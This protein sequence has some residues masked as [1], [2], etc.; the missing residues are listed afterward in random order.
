MQAL[1]QADVTISGKLTDKDGSPIPGANVFIQGT[2]NGTVTDAEGNYTITVAKGATLRFA[3]AGYNEKKV[4]VGNQ[5]VINLSLDE[6][7]IEAIT[8]TSYGQVIDKTTTTGAMTSVAG[9][10]FETLPLQSFDRAIQGRLAGVAVN[11]ANG[12]P[13]GGLQVR[14][15]G[16][17]SVLASNAPLYIVD[18]VQ[19][20]AGAFSTQA[21]ATGSVTGTNA[22][23][24]INPNDIETVEVLKDAAAAAI[25]GAQS[26]N[27]VVII[28]TKKGKRNSDQ[29]NFTIQE[30]F[31]EPIRLF[32]VL[33][34][35]QYATLKREAA[36]NDLFQPNVTPTSAQ[37]AAAIANANTLYGNPDTT[38]TNFDWVGAV[39]R[40]A[41]LRTYDVNYSGGNDRTRFYISAS[42]Q[43][44]EGQIIRSNW[45]RGSVRFNIDH[46]ASKR[47][48]L[49]SSNTVSN[50][51]IFGL[52]N[53]GEGNF[54]NS[55]TFIFQ[56]A[57]TK[58]AYLPDGSFATYSD[59]VLAFNYNNL[60]GLNL[61]T[62]K[63]SAV[64][65]VSSLKGVYNIL[66]SL[67]FTSFVGVDWL[68]NRDENIRP[69]TIPVFAPGNMTNR[70]DRDLSLNTNYTLNFTKKIGENHNVSALAG[71]EYRYRSTMFTNALGRSFNP[72]I[73]VLNGVTNGTTS[74]T[75]STVSGN[76]IE[77][78]RAGFFGQA[79]YNFKE[80]YFIDGTFRRDGSSKFGLKN[81]YGNFYAASA[82]WRISEEA[83]MEGIKDQ[84]SE[85]KIRGSYGYVGNSEID[86][87]Q[88]VTTFTTSGVQYLG[89][90]GSR[91]AVLGNDLLTWE[92]S[93]Q[94]NLGLDFGFLRGSRIFG[95]IDF[96]R[97]DTQD[98]LF[99]VS[100]AADAGQRPSS[101]IRNVGKIR[102]QGIDFEIGANILTNPE[103]LRWVSSFNITYQTN[104]VLELPENRNLLI[105]AGRE[106]FKGK[107]L[108][109]FVLPAYAGVNPA[110]GQ[111]MYYDANNNITYNPLSYQVRDDLSIDFRDD[112]TWGTALPR[113]FGG[114]NNQF[115]Y[116]GITLDF[117][118]QYQY[119][120]VTYNSD[121]WAN[122]LTGMEGGSNNVD[123]VLE[124]W[125]QPGDITNVPRL[126]L[127]G[128]YNG[129]SLTRAS[130][131]YIEDASYVRLKT[132]SLGYNISSEVL[133]GFKSARVF[134]Q[135]VN[136]LTFTKANVIDPEVV[137]TATNSTSL[138]GGINQFP[139][140]RQFSVGATF[141]F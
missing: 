64:Q 50:Q 36:I 47:F 128:S 38:V 21:G 24:S 77:S 11:A 4:V 116:K 19:V 78:D 124:R 83:F 79:K 120:G 87:Y 112:R 107:P 73:T 20:T 34:G 131:R 2:N 56:N 43:K 72:N 10:D 97:R 85:L 109:T 32:K 59:G 54:L 14:I 96:W 44:Q 67:S 22:L 117:L 103:G 82:G 74:T 35:Q 80:K 12:S 15:R 17:G 30:G 134:I 93:A 62:R 18:G 40:R 108:S 39:F 13:G 136:L 46:K 126:S 63:G 6:E 125:T 66:P 89:V 137:G 55:S 58:S 42:Y 115:S 57:P 95:S 23:G 65:V 130:S 88:N 8:V 111:P 45:E 132:V 123:K 31:V 100:I 129:V 52:I 90:V 51:S 33:N 114:W 69:R 37:I 106:V 92:G 53:G 138:L 98:A 7:Q 29:I 91:P 5:A 60:Q 81:R 84:L 119:G 26:A 75:L 102:N 27:G 86:D 121:W 49:Q 139:Q 104:E 140:G 133:K 141:G 118:W 48:T 127:S 9:K 1:G 68:N 61:E 70:Y 16:T 105:V 25:Y 122:L 94:T 76:V 101:I 41:R 110:T 135:A 28:T 99:S 3:A 71:Y 113:F